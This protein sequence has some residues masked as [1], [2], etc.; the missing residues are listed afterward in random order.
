MNNISKTRTQKLIALTIAYLVS[1]QGV[2]IGINAITD[3]MKINVVWDTAIVYLL[4]WGLSLYGIVRSI[5]FYGIKIDVFILLMVF[6]LLF[7]VTPIIF[8]ENTK[9]IIPIDADF[10]NSPILA[11]FV[12]SFLGYVFIRYLQ[13]YDHLMKYLRIF[14]YIVILLSV[15]I[16]FFLK[17]SF[18]V[19]YM[20]LSYN[21][22]LQVFF[23]MFDK[24]RHFGI[25]KWL[26]VIAGTF[27]IAVGGARGAL[28][29]LLIGI[30]IRIAL[31]ASASKLKKCIFIFVII[32]GIGVAALFY[33]EL[34]SMLAK[35]LEEFNVSSRTIELL[36]SGEGVNSSG[37][38]VLQLKLLSNYSIL[39]YG[40]FGD[41]V[42][43]DGTYAHNV[44]IEW[45][46]DFGVIFGSVLSIGFIAFFV[47]AFRNSKDK[48]RN[49]IILF[50]PSGLIAIQFSGTYLAYSPC[51]YI[52]L[53]L[54]VN[55]IINNRC[56]D[57]ICPKM[58]KLKGE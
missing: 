36:V 13:D 7:M 33:V 44:F 34:I 20:S 8:P 18:A 58:K 9:Y 10:S 35:F 52:L 27:V 3:A 14:S 31:G 1:F 57:P 25:I 6:T 24:S 42:I 37:R 51:F 38:D 4:L 48:L 28:V 19:E 40:I 55:V 26:A 29:S 5:Y 45:L 41:K 22:L 11:F 15:I 17:D 43:L 12:H 54:C 53:G 46:T 50:I 16:Y 32:F 30:V 49:S 21:M 39:G 47:K 56:K 23:L 2:L